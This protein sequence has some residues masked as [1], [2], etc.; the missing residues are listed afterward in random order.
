MFLDRMIEEKIWFQAALQAGVAERP[1]VQQKLE[2][3]RRDILVRTYLGEEMQKVPA[4]TDSTVQAYYDAHPDEFLTEEQVRVRHVQVPDEKTAGKVRAELGK[5]GADFAA[6]AKKYSVD[7]VTKDKGGDLGLVAKSGF[8]GSLGR[9]PAFAESAFAAPLNTIEGPLKTGLGWHVYE[10]TER[11][12]AHPRP[13]DEVRSLILRQLTQQANQDWYQQQLALTRARLGVVV[14]SSAIDSLLNARKS[15]VEMF[16]EAGEQPDPDQRIRAY[17]QVVEL[18]PQSEYAPQA[19]FMVGFVESEEKRDYD[20]AEAAFRDL[21][22][23]YPGSELVASAQWM[24]D[25]MRTDATPDFE[26][27][28]G[29]GAASGHASPDNQ[30]ATPKH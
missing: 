17:R 9:Q 23:R 6:V 2:S 24:I 22:A 16:R 7:A 15:A 29:L 26:L 25:N 12:A 1:D 14:D 10:V 4:P 20:K 8:F 11:V 19:L 3:D 18:Y 28:G 13:L 30:P 21:L 27:P 5:S